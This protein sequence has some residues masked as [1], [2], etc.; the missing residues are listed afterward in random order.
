VSATPEWYKEFYRG[1]IGRD[2]DPNARPNKRRLFRRWLPYGKWTCADG[3]QVLFNRAYRPIWERSPGQPA[4]PADVE[5]WVEELVREEWFYNDGCRPCDSDGFKV[6]QRCL[7]VLQDFG[8]SWEPIAHYADV[9]RAD[10]LAA[11]QVS[12]GTT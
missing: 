11:A 6:L 9:R 12:K 1:G 4:K 5:E 3:R 8:A 10:S 7:K 2:D